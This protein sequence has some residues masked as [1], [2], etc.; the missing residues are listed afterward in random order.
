MIKWTVWNGELI[1][2]KQLLIRGLLYVA[3]GL[4]WMGL[5]LIIPFALLFLLTFAGRGNYG[6]PL[7]LT[8]NPDGSWQWHLNFGNYIRLLG[9]GGEHWDPA[10]LR[11]VVRTL[12]MSAITTVVC[13]LMA[14]PICFFIASRTPRWRYIWLLLIMI[15]FCTNLVIRATAWQLLVSKEF[16]LSEFARWL[17]LLS[18]ATLQGRCVQWLGLVEAG[19]SL[20]PSNLAIYLGMISSSL[21]FAV[22]P[23]YTNV[24]RMD[25][26]LVEAARD[27]YASPWRIVRHAILPQTTPGLTVA[28]I[29]T[30]IPAMGMFVIPDI[31]GGA[32]IYY[33][34]NVIQAQFGSSKDFGYGS[35]ISLILMLLTLVGLMVYRSKAKGMTPL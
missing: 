12:V 23:L 15:P 25:W 20:L 34:G 32:R 9:L 8:A 2:R 7:F 30:F 1:S 29:L 10:N 5:L 16:P 24:E 28:I 26:A 17:G 35:A 31:L 6:D 21:P 33:I 14:Y 19:E 27:L 18:A 4:F 3:P 22:L 13:I 11:I